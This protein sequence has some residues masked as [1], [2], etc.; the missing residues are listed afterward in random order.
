[1]QLLGRKTRLLFLFFAIALVLYPVL[2]VNA[3][4]PVPEMD[5]KRYPAPSIG[6]L[7]PGKCHAGI[8][9]IRAHNSEMAKQIYALGSKLGDPNGC[10]VCHGGNPTEEKDA[11]KAHTGAPDGSPLDTFV[12][13]SASVWVNE[14]ICGQCHQAWVYAQYRSIMQTEAGKI[15]GALWGWGPV[16]T[17]YA[18]R[19]G[20]YDVDDPDGPDPVF[21]TK[22][23]K[24]Y[25]KAL[26]QAHPN[27]FPA[28]LLQVPATNVEMIKE[29]PQ[30]A[31]Y[32]YMRTD[33][34]RCHVGSKDATGVATFAA[35]AVQP[36]ISPTTM[37][38]CMKAMT[39]R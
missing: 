33:C 20:N 23:Y 4:D 15:Q 24:E 31:I 18:K 7:V 34:Q 19:Y 3:E 29:N 32:T 39:R 2:P 36:A 25:T 35:W 27:N 17:G 5:P 16:S 12:L 30:E 14:K 8:E 1:M 22:E 21:G 11:K 9:P 6:C 38:D 28:K 26:M 37:P 10:V 13:H